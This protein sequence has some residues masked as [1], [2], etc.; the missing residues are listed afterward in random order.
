MEE[1]RER[2]FTF[3]IVFHIFCLPVYQIEVKSIHCHQP[4]GQKKLIRHCKEFVVI[5]VGDCFCY[6]RSTAYPSWTPSSTTLPSRM[7]T[8]L[9]AFSQLP[10]DVL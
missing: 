7:T 5:F 9:S 6:V 2:G 3:V 1:G 8:I 10:V 4:K